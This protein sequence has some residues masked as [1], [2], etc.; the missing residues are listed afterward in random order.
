M[1]K[2]FIVVIM[3]FVSCNGTTD[4]K[5]VHYESG[6]TYRD[7]ASDQ[8]H[9]VYYEGLLKSVVYDSRTDS[10]KGYFYSSAV[11]KDTMKI[12][13]KDLDRIANN[14]YRYQIH[15]IKGVRNGG[16]SASTH[17][18]FS[19]VVVFKNHTRIAELNVWPDDE[20]PIKAFEDSIS[21]ILSEQ[22]E[23]NFV[24]DTLFSLYSKKPIMF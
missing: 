4:S 24:R 6:K 1:N 2:A 19:T 22:P 18:A 10:L 15:H 13:V 5:N 11:H 9:L 17:S 23:Y 8:Y 14:F 16:K 12:S 3:A 21:K 7:F 20:G